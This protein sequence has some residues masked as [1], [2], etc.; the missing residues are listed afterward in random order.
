MGNPSK[1]GGLSRSY[2]PD[3]RCCACGVK[4]LV[5]PNRGVHPI[6]WVRSAAD[7]DSALVVFVRRLESSIQAGNPRPRMFMMVLLVVVVT[8]CGPLG[9]DEAPSRVPSTSSTGNL[10]PARMATATWLS[11]AAASPTAAFQLSPA[12]S[13]FT[14]ALPVAAGTP[15][16]PADPGTPESS[17]PAGAEQIV[18]NDC[19][20]PDPLPSPE[21]GGPLITIDEAVNIRRGPGTEC[22]VIQLLTLGS[23]M[24]PLSGTVEASGVSWILVDIDGVQGWVALEF[25]AEP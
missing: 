6:P 23:T 13:P 21:Q 11:P 4:R 9:N 1:S 18:A 20:A 15:V 5:G 22:E 12:A 17:T 8:G 25:L 16:E 3:S 10:N 24:I 19:E 14:I 7:K 2:S